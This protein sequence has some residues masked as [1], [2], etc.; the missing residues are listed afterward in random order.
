MEFAID[1]TEKFD[2][3]LDDTSADLTE[4]FLFHRILKVEVSSKC[5]TKVDEKPQL[6]TSSSSFKFWQNSPWALQRGWRF[7]CLSGV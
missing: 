1:V 4:K 5:V 7:P 3:K 6:N 2:P